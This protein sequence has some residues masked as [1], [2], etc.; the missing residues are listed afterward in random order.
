MLQMLLQETVNRHVTAFHRRFRGLEGYLSPKA[1]V[2]RCYVSIHSFPVIIIIIII[3]LPRVS[4]N[5]RTLNG[6]IGPDSEATTACK[7]SLNTGWSK[8]GTTKFGSL[9]TSSNSNRFT[10]ICH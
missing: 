9:I 1:S 7:V 2:K 6:D 10:Q 8:K 3:Y 5:K 4:S